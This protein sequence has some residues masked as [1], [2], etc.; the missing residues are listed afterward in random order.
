MLSTLLP[1]SANALALH[2][3]ILSAS[4]RFCARGERVDAW[5]ALP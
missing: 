4:T 1:P 5:N 2:L 3:L